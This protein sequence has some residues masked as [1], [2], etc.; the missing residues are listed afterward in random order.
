MISGRKVLVIIPARGGS[1][2]IPRK[3]LAPIGNHPLIAFAI[4][5]AKCVA[6]IDRIAVSTEDSEIATVAIQYGATVP[7]KRPMELALDDTPMIEVITHM[8]TSLEEI[9][10]YYDCVCIL[11]PTSPFRNPET[12]ASGIMT[13]F[14][15]SDSD[16]CLA[17][18]PVVDCH[19]KRIRKI[20][21]GYVSNYLG[22]MGDNERQQRQGHNNDP[23]YRRCGTFYITRTNTIKVKHSLYG[24]RALPL[25]VE[26]CQAINIDDPFDLLLA[27]S[28]WNKRSEFPELNI[29]NQ[30]LGN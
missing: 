7:V 10:E 12:I 3:N 8:L 15:N 11:Q 13:L 20:E 29:I 6:G 28:I 17:I 4:A 14:S 16:S 27:K 26:G 24:E 22:D 1:K 19:P 23:A 25:I 21:N 2:G 30:A 18:T 9:G 5:S